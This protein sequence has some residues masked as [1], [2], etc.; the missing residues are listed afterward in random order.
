M[1][2]RDTIVFIFHN[3]HVH[4]VIR[5]VAS[6]EQ[7]RIMFVQTVQITVHDVSCAHN[8]RA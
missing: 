3:V 6:P 7:V 2:K 1:D 4:Y 8:D 5:I